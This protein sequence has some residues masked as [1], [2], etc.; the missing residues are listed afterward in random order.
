MKRIARYALVAFLLLPCAFAQRRHP[1]ASSNVTAGQ[2]TLS[3]TSIAFGNVAVTDITITDLKIT[4]TG[5][6]PVRL[7]DITVTNVTLF[8]AGGIAS[9]DAFSESSTGP[10]S[11]SCALTASDVLA[12][13][14]A[15]R[16]W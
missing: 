11:A 5:T 2:I 10:T 12:G 4:N 13:S 16:T 1:K 6:V 9:D 3:P 7:S 15:L 8:T 14:P